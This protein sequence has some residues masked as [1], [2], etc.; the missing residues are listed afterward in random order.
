MESP[1]EL[2]ELRDLL[3]QTELLRQ[4]PLDQLLAENA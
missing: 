3:L 2:T 4:D 1:P